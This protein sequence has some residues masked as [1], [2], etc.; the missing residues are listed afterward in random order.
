MS[1]ATLTLL[2]FPRPEPGEDT[3]PAPVL[4]AAAS[5]GLEGVVV[6]G[7]TKNGEEYFDSSYLDGP[8]VAWLAQR[9]LHK[10]MSA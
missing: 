4:A 1:K 7:F 2:T 8:L 5:A 3:D 6:M 10:L 9:A